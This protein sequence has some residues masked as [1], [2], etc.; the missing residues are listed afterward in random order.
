[1][2][3]DLHCATSHLPSKK[4]VNLYKFHLLYGIKSLQNDLQR[5]KHGCFCPTSTCRAWICYTLPSL[6]EGSHRDRCTCTDRW[7]MHWS[8]GALV[9][10]S[11]DNDGSHVVWVCQQFLS[12]EG[13]VD[14]SWPAHPT[15]LS[16]ILHL[17]DIVCHHV[18]SAVTMWYHI[19]S[20]N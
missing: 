1:M 2:D 4:P 6:G 19:L 15:D 13:S 20:G 10:T 16:S 18:A 3:Q 12:D 8:S 11:Q 17:W 14:A 9:P 5:P 7:V